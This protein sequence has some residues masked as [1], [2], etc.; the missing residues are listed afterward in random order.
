V[1]ETNLLTQRTL[2]ER[3]LSALTLPVTF[4]RPA[5]FMENFAWDVASA[6]YHGVIAS[7]LQPPNAPVACISLAPQSSGK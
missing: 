1:T 3:A 2:L 7:F 6:R 5:W 4:L